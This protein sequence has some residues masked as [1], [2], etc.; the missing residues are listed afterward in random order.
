MESPPV[1]PILSLWVVF[2][3]RVHPTI[4]AVGQDLVALLRLMSASR[5]NT[6]GPTAI[7]TGA[8]RF[9]TLGLA[10]APALHVNGPDSYDEVVLG[11]VKVMAIKGGGRDVIDVATPPTRGNFVGSRVFCLAFVS[12][13]QR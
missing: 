6:G 10:S 11:N 2:G 4:L 1:E 12:P 13:D 7:V 8:I 5:D 3:G 9:G